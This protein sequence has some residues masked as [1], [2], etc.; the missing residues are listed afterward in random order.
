MTLARSGSGWANGSTDG[1]VEL[2][3]DPPCYLAPGIDTLFRRR[4]VNLLTVS[5]VDPDGLIPALERHGH[6]VTEP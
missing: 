3:I 2:A 6:L 5:L 1:L 4:K